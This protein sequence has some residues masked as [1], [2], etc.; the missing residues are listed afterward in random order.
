MTKPEFEAGKI[1][2]VTFPDGRVLIVK[3]IGGSHTKFQV[4][5]GSMIGIEQLDGRISVEEIDDELRNV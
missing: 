3:L 4:K 2:K 5:D 1:Y